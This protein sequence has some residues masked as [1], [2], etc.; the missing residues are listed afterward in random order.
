MSEKECLCCLHSCTNTHKLSTQLAI[1]LCRFP[2][3]AEN[4]HTDSCMHVGYPFR[5]SAKHNEIWKQSQR[6][7]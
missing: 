5:S 1:Q 7:C 4:L 2:E 3:Q 6:L